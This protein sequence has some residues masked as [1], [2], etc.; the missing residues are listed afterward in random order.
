MNL[1]AHIDRQRVDRN[2]S[3]AQKEAGN[4]RKAH[5]SIHGLD[6]AIE[7]P[8]GS[9]RKGVDGDGKPW[10]CRLPA[11]YGYIKR[12]E[13]A[14]G[15]HV[16]V[17]IGPHYKSPHVYVIDQHDLKYGKY[18]EHKVMLGFAS[19]GQAK[20]TYHRA[21][22]DDNGKDRIGHIETMTVDEFKNWLS[23]GDTTAPIKHRAEGGRVHLA[24]GG[25]PVTDPDVLSQLN[26]PAPVTDPALLAQLNAP[27]PPDQG[28]L[29]ALGHGAASGATFGFSDELRGV[30]AA[31]PE[32][33]PE[34]VGPL[35]AKMM[36]GAARL[37]KNYLMGNDP[38]ALTAYEKSRDEERQAQASAKANHPYYYGAGEIAGSIP[39]MA[40]LPEAGATARLAPMA[41][42]LAKFGAATTDAAALG[43][44]YG[45]LSGAGEGTDLT[46]RATNA[47]SGLVGG[48]IGGA[49]APVLGKV[50][51]AASNKF[52]QPGVSAIR[53]W[54][55][56]EGEAG[57]RLALALQKDQEMIAQ[58]TAK[59]MS[60][61][62][63]AAARQ[64]GEPVTLAD[65]GAGNTQA[66][67]R[68]AANTSPEGRAML[69]KV[70]EDRFLGQSERVASDV[71]GLVAGGANAG[72]TSEDLV[73][74]YDAARKPAYQQAYREGDKEIMTPEME[75]IMGSPMV[76]EAMRRASVSGKDRAITQGF[77]AFNPGVTVENGLVKF[78]PKPNGV[79]TYPNLQFWDA[80]KRELDDIASSAGRSGE[81]GKAQVAGDLAKTLR[82]ELDQQVPSYANARGIASQF[83]GENNALEAGRSL[84]GKRVDPQVIQGVMGKMKPDERDL[85]REGYASDWANRVINNISDT[86]DITKAMFNSPNERARALAVFGPAGMAKIQARMTL[87]TIMDGARK[88]MGNS[89]TARQLIE[90]GLAGGALEGYMSGWDPTRM[91]EGAAGAAGAR[92]FLGSEMAAGARK[93]IGK[94]DSTTARTVARL[95]T[96]N[97]PNDLAQGLRMATKNQKIANGLKSIANRVALSSLAPSAREQAIRTVPMLQGAV[98]AHADDKQPQPPRGINQ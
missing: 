56:P 25:A 1:A 97:D 71:R 72:K 22:S 91:A 62:E 51:E 21:F 80:T 66:L 65:L 31:A 18:D 93:L 67:L 54:I 29:H 87:E 57:R 11:H 32:A 12:T 92:K 9:Y 69:E 94:V 3:E 82:G 10:R 98:G 4:Y 38:E 2:P 20:A 5:I 64:A 52:I 76:V 34:M 81:K 37:A 36:A 15:D 60:P 28:A 6:I 35:P 14:D 77:G 23:D 49:A 59:G 44:E 58:G 85:F 41:G 84:A 7:N 95:L 55:N 46:S 17:Y 86:R 8:C 30:H 13:G 26:A 61:Q 78:Q 33:V 70:I 79:P 45:A 63:W 39:A 68:S 89:T 19:K 40:A 73:A 27:P 83:F 24:D 96:S 48:V 50:A 53:G 47:G 90:A 74:A 75:R 42:R 16:D 88:A 43:G